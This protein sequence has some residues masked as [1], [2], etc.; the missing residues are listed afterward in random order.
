[1]YLNNQITFEDLFKKQILKYF[2]KD[3]DDIER[4]LFPYRAL[5]EI[6]LETKELSQLHFTYPISSMYKTKESIEDTIKGIEFINTE[7]PNPDVLNE[8][9]KRTLVQEFNAIWNVEHTFENVW[10]DRTTLYNQFIYFR[11]HLGLFEDCIESDSEKGRIKVINGKEQLILD[12]LKQDYEMA[13]SKE[14][15]EL[16]SRYINFVSVFIVSLGGLS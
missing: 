10:T 5:L 13:S 11:N 1:M 16:I 9:N 14:R 2:I 15:N 4:V 8:A 7:Y 3:N 12:L 6:L